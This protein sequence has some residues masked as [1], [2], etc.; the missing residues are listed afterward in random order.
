M[1]M[2]KQ[3]RIILDKV[4]SSEDHPTVDM[5]YQSVRELLPRISL[6]TVY[7]NL[8]MLSENGLISRLSMNDSRKHYDH[9][10]TDHYHIRCLNCGRID[11]YHIKSILP[12]S[13]VTS[14]KRYN[15]QGFNLEFYGI[16]PACQK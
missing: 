8:E 12:A 2:T 4:R 9:D 3:R 14:N 11:D 15:V 5:I 16:C 7:R 6:G 13:Q 10:L 1:R